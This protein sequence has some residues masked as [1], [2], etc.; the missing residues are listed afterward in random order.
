MRGPL[1][2]AR[3][4]RGRRVSRPWQRRGGRRRSGGRGRSRARRGGSRMRR[5]HDGSR[6]RGRRMR[7]RG[8]GRR[9]GGSRMR[10]RCSGR[11]MCN[12]RG[13]RSRSN[14]SSRSRCMMH[15]R[16]MR[17]RSGRHLWRWRRRCSVCG[18]SA[19]RNRDGWRVRRLARRRRSRSQAGQRRADRCTRRR[20]R[21]GGRGS[22]RGRGLKSGFFH[23]G[24]MDS[25]NRSVRCSG[26]SGGRRT[27]SGMR[28]GIPLVR[29][30]R[31]SAAGLGLVME[32]RTAVAGQAFFDRQCDIF[33]NGARMGLLLR[34]AE[35]RQQL[36]DG[37][38]FDF[39]FASQLVYANLLHTDGQSTR[40][41]G[42]SAITSWSARLARSVRITLL[43]EDPW[44]S[45]YQIH[46]LAVRR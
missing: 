41:Q 4:R 39:Q 16:H 43:Q 8:R 40:A 11:S 18:N 10:S 7:R 30:F 21:R 17:D 35:D 5:Q 32:Q 3:L 29:A 34:D 22:G 9:G 19:R 2:R 13:G 36:Q 45:S 1:R 6:S 15:R 42:S 44:S 28:F 20:R 25:G 33:V 27:A 24:S 14:W 12:R 26:Q 37:A 46:P 23:N 31:L 38:R